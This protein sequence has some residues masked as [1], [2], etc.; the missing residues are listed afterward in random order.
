MSCRRF[1]ENLNAYLDRVLDPGTVQDLEAHLADCPRC[2][3]AVAFERRL[4]H[5][6]REAMPP[7]PAPPGLRARILDAL[8]ASESAEAPRRRRTGWVAGG[9][10]AAGLAA[11]VAWFSLGQAPGI[12]PKAAEAIVRDHARHLQD[13]HHLTVRASRSQDVEAW[14]QARLPY[15]VKVPA[16]ESA[17]ARVLGGRVCRVFGKKNA[18]VSFQKNGHRVAIYIFNPAWVRTLPGSRRALAPDRTPYAWHEAGPY[19]LVS[20]KDAENRVCVV[21]STLSKEELLSVVKAAGLWRIH[22]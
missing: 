18:Y 17:G 11:L 15:P 13:P 5:L 12:S 1:Q 3:T 9:L 8:A 20:W 2:Q 6:L 19:R 14:L 10:A 21:I 4:R 16:L 22:A 7:E